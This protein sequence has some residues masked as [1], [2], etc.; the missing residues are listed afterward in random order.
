MTKRNQLV[1]PQAE[2]LLNNLK[3]EIAEEFGIK[4]GAD[5]T[6]RDNGRV[7]GEMT[8]RLIRLAQEQLAGENMKH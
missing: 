3:N 1:V 8:K 2:I 6:A 7:G 5:A 4:L